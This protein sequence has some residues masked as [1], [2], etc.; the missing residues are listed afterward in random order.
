MVNMARMFLIVTL[1]SGVDC[2]GNDK[3]IVV[4]NEDDGD[5]GDD[6]QDGDDGVDD[7]DDGDG[8]EHNDDGGDD[9][10]MAMMMKVV[11]IRRGSLGFVLHWSVHQHRPTDYSA[12]FFSPHIDHHDHT[13]SM[14]L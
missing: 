11:M 3:K 1:D 7:H 13:R 9:K 6:D 12:I 8:V 2:G 10:M 5:D 4:L 14:I